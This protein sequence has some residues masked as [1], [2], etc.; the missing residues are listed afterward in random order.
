MPPP[1]RRP[2]RPPGCCWS[3]GG[4]DLGSGLA[5]EIA[6]WIKIWSPQMMGVE[7]PKPGI[8]VFH[9]RLFVSVQAVGG[10]ACGA[11]PLPSGPRHCGQFCSA[12]APKEVAIPVKKTNPANRNFDIMFALRP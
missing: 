12:E 7:V 11:T 1:P 3:A 5:D 9:L 6:V 4:N 8:F 10:L 2:G